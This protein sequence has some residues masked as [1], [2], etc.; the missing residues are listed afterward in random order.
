MNVCFGVCA[1]ILMMSMTLVNGGAKL[2]RQ[3]KEEIR[4]A[5]ETDAAEINDAAR[6]ETDSAQEF[7]FDAERFEL[8]EEAAVLVVVEG[9][10]QR[11]CVLRAFEKTDGEWQLQLETDGWLG[12]N[13][14]SNHRTMGDET[15]PIGVF[16]MNTPFGQKAALEGFPDHYIQVD[17]SYIWEDERNILSRE[18]SKEGE[19]VGG[20]GYTEAYGYAVDMGF[21][22]N[23][24]AGMGSALFLHCAIARE[25]GTSGCVAVPEDAMIRILRLYGKYGDGRCYIALAPSGTFEQIYDAYGVNDGLSPDGDFTADRPAG[26]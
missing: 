21:N 5:A 20:P 7:S 19:L 17:G 11:Q 22:R 9:V 8:P 12:R 1:V 24:V 26:Q 13:G 10:G 16:Q 25:A 3:M 4:I 15:T 14:L 23:A 18:L 2:S 6:E